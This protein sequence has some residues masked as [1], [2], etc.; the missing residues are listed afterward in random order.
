[1]KDRRLAVRYARALLAALPDP[2]TA[3]SAD[4]FLATLSQGIETSDEVRILMLDP[5]IPR[6]QRTA[7]LRELAS[8]QGQPTAVSNFLATLV[9]NN[10]TA[11]V[12]TIAAVYHEE[13]EKREGIVPAE[14][15]TATP[16]SDDLRDRA[17]QALEKV[18]GRSVELTC[19]VEPSLIGGAVTRVGS[20]VYDG[21]LRTQLSRLRRAMTQ[22]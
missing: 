3:K 2:Q 20:K 14:I 16:M 21:S 9:E 12:P 15:T 7:A 10:R 8:N 22:E 6:G 11:V 1:M 19:R 13:L 18:T 5:A 4:E 17:R